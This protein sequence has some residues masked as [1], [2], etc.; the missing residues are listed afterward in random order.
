MLGFARRGYRSNAVTHDPQAL[1]ELAAFIDPATNSRASATED[2]RPALTALAVAAFP[3]L[4]PRLLSD[5]A[6]LD[7][8]F[9]P[10]WSEPFGFEK[11]AALLARESVPEAMPAVMRRFAARHRLR[12]AL[13]EILPQSAGGTSILVAARELSD[14]AAATIDA[15]LRVG[16]REVQARFG[17]PMRHDGVRSTLC[18]VGMGKLGGGEL[19]AGSDVD[20]VCFYD[21]DEGATD[22]GDGISLHEFWTRV[23][24]RLVPLLDEV[25]ADGFVWRVD[26]RL[27]PEGTRGPLVNSLPAMLRYYETW[28]RTWERAAWT[29]AR[30]IAG[31]VALGD[32]LL[33]ELEPFVYR[34]SVDPRI[35]SAMCDLVDQARSESGH[36]QR[37]LKLG[38]GGI[39]E[40]ETF[41]QALQ[42]V[43]G[44]KDRA[45]RP[46]PTL[47]ALDRLRSHGFVTEREATNLGE[48]YILLRSAEHLVQN[49][50][51]LQTHLLPTDERSRL[52]LARCL[53]FETWKGFEDELRQVQLRVHD[54]VEGLRSGDARALRWTSLFAAID[55]ADISR[56]QSVLEEPLHEMATRELAR[57]LIQLGMQPDV[58]LGVVAR[59]R[60]PIHAESLVDA[61]VES[62]DPEQAARSL[63]AWSSHRTFKP[64]HA[65]TLREPPALLR[66]FVTALGG[67][68]FLG[69]LI[70]RHPELAE[71][72]LFSRGMPSTGAAAKA[73]DREVHSLDADDRLDP[74]SVAGAIRRAKIRVTLEVVLADIAE[75]VGVVDVTRV[76][77]ALADACVQ[78]ALEVAAGSGDATAGMCVLS[79]GKLGGEELGYGSDLDV[80]FVFEPRGDEDENEVMVR[81]V[82]QAQKAIRVLSGVHE[83]GP[84]YELDT[85]LRPSGAQGVLVTSLRAFARYHGIGT[86]EDATGLRAAP[87]ERQTLLRARFT[88]GDAALGKR[89]LSIAHRAAY[90]AGP[91]DLSEVHR[92]RLR[93][94]KELGREKGGRFDIKLGRGGLVD[95]EFAV[96][97]MQMLHGQEASVRTTH[98]LEAIH[99]LGRCGAIQ[100]DDAERLREGYLFLR[101]LEQRLHVVHNASIHLLEAEAPG[102]LPL[103]RRMG[104]TRSPSRSAPDQ[105]LDQYTEITSSVRETYLTLMGVK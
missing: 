102:L 20:L 75:E 85:R 95:I 8:C 89:V 65:S 30:P 99:A 24:R 11:Y 3:T 50:S 45:L 47:E 51:G 59:D 61:L 13:R 94:E 28:G 77:S 100:S 6:L 74:E 92:L 48:A 105:L 98:T 87:W 5:P 71:H 26:L 58:L 60:A 37:D 72:V 64:V 12:V 44:G 23:V 76:L 4:E 90:E 31:D 9:E 83:Q 70:V 29:R 25:T 32:A 1:L 80:L 84:G 49:A 79:V 86:G 81:R 41:V 40:L 39:R 82:R 10:R 15:A 43:W 17:T 62:A 35:A 2:P 42:L 67:S 36:G 19:N 21:T 78:T 101:K 18:I 63:C 96:Q 91:P 7:A 53:G 38:P 46:R 52:R 68:A 33:R 55:E 66:R 104:L 14:L 88:A 34:R 56:V 27:R 73:V 22:G 54:C 69:D 57:D 16:Y 93:L 97:A 103:A